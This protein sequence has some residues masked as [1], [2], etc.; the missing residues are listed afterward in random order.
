MSKAEHHYFAQLLA[1]VVGALT[2]LQSRV[3]GEL[4]V[5]V[6]SG[7]Q[8]AMVSF[9]TGLIMLSGYA[10]FSKS[11]R[12]GLSN[13]Y[14]A[15]KN[16]KIFWWQCV[17]GSVGA[18]F[19]AIQS[20]TVPLVGVAIFTIAT[21]GGQ[22]ASS[23]V[24]DRLGV[25][26]QGK[27]QPTLNR[28]VA[29]I[30]AIIAVGVSVSNRI[31]GGDI[32]VLAVIA[33]LGVGAGVSFQHS[34]NGHVNLQAQ[35]PVTA[36]LLNFIVGTTLLYVV[37]AVGTLNGSL[38]FHPLPNGPFYLYLGGL[39]G[40]LFIV[41]ASRVI[42]TLGSLKF[43]MGSVTGQLIGSLLLDIFVPTAGAVISIQLLA[44][45]ALTA[46]AVVLANL[47]TRISV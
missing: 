18:S 17:G 13:L 41:T 36:A 6:E 27:I 20:I 9:T 31:E 12:A 44:A 32:P 47:K 38:Q 29:A 11:T 42:K 15:L 30:V 46:A 45:I 22:I 3:N 14:A 4:S 5:L 28:V 43:A 16:R 33:A 34:F 39:F 35:S 37:F 7:I 24:V 8:A 1:V 40:L 19:V 26:P 2:T 25:G 23:L 10:V 21:V